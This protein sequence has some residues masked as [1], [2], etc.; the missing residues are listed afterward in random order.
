MPVRML[1]PR[2]L[3]RI[4]ALAR[5]VPTRAAGGAAAATAKRGGAPCWARR[6]FRVVWGGGGRGGG[7]PLQAEGVEFDRGAAALTV[8]PEP[9]G[10]VDQ[11]GRRITPFVRSWRYP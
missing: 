10:G 6:P 5:A 8:I 3:A 4:L 11:A 7:G 9:S 1:T 2:A